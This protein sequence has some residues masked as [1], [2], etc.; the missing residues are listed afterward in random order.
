MQQNQDVWSFLD[1]VELCRVFSAKQPNRLQCVSHRYSKYRGGFSP[2]A[3]RKS[4]AESPTNVPFL[5]SELNAAR[6]T[7][8]IWASRAFW[9]SV[10][11]GHE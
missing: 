6:R 2:K 7:N 4:D 9:L 8:A 5:P 1:D 10:D 3:L 11:E